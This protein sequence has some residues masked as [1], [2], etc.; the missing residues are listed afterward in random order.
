M[1]RNLKH[2]WSGTVSSSIGNITIG[3]GCGHGLPTSPE[4]I[5]KRRLL[6]LLF[7]ASATPERVFKHRGDWG[8]LHHIITIRGRGAGRGLRRGIWRRGASANGRGS[9]G[10]AWLILPLGLLGLLSRL[11]RAWRLVYHFGIV[12]GCC[13]GRS[14]NHNLW[15]SRTV[16]KNRIGY[17]YLLGISVHFFPS[18][19]QYFSALR[20]KPKQ[21]GKCSAKNCIIPV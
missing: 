18:L 6:R 20:Y 14:M 19:I 7:G 13:R 5:R 15:S 4:I 3:W 12:R 11:H 10:G 16:C 9:S 8:A 1:I 17:F 2:S 21:G